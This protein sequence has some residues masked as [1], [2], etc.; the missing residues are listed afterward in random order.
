MPYVG[1]AGRHK[2]AGN[3]RET[4]ASA[5]LRF[6]QPHTD[7][8]IVVRDL[9]ATSEEF[10]INTMRKGLAAAGVVALITA[11]AAACGNEEP[12]TPQGKVSNAFIQLG[13]QK[14]VTLG[15]SFDGTPDQIYAALKD[16]DDFKRADADLI[17]GLRVSTSFSADKALA[18]LSGDD[19]GI[20]FGVEVA[21]GA[22]GKSEGKTLIGLRS[23]DQKAYVQVDL[24]GLAAL[25]T[26]GDA[27]LSDITG[28]LGSVDQLPSSFGSI[29]TLAKGGWV[30]IDPKA[31]AEFA[32]TLGDDASGD[33]ASGSGSGSG[34][35]DGSDDSPLGGLGL[36]SGLPTG[37]P[38]DLA[39]KT[40]AELLAPLQK[41]LTK[42]AKITDLGSQD[43]ADHL[44]VSVP[45]R[46]LAQ[47]LKSSLGSMAKVLPGDL[48]KSL[49]DVPNKTV[50]LDVA[51]KG[52]KLTHVSVDLAQFD[53]TIHGKL[54]LGLSVDGG[55]D[56]V[57]AP[58]GAQQLNPQDL[59]G[60]LMSQL[61]DF[62]VKADKL[63]PGAF[64]ARPGQLT[65]DDSASA[66][67]PADQLKDL[68]IDLS[69]L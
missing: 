15:L 58:A 48:Q 41:S 60:A 25:D 40:F 62:K 17:A 32:K 65:G 6:C 1:N 18:E 26:T 13:E 4:T 46:S 38:T 8:H 29:K 5:Q 10:V 34:S 23:V 44:K 3:P 52:G 63:D 36:P 24:K 55:A 14:S 59:M 53:D 54:P 12:S 39:H 37:L 51:V 61:G 2:S 20:S 22:S 64:T 33:S 35:D 67:A 56:P 57:K 42:D 11:G 21:G 69:G 27:G 31:F 30:S 16:Q 49:D 7:T 19:K 9:V 28:M 68:H 47:D 45:A 66:Q 43:G 50:A